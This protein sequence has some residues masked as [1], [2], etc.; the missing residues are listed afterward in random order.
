MAKK[1]TKTKKIIIAVV[2][3][4]AALL[5][6]FMILCFVTMG[7]YSPTYLGRVLT[8]WDSRVTDY[9]FFPERI[10][11]K[12]ASPYAYE[13]DI[14]SNL[15]GFTVN[16]KS[17]KRNKS[18]ALSSFV[19]KT[20]TTSLIIVKDDKI[21]YEQY[22]NGYTENSVNTSFSMSK[23]VVSLLVGKAVEEGYIKSVTQ[24]I[25][26]YI[27][28]FED[29]P[30][31]KVTIED[32]LLMRSPIKYDEEKPLW[33]GDDTLT[34]FYD[35]LRALALK[36]TKLTDEYGGRFHYNN[37][38][39]L[40]LGIILERSTGVSVSKYFERTIWQPIGCEADASWSLDGKKSA[41]EKMESGI[42]FRALDFIK[43]GSMVLHGGV[44]N[45]TRIIGE[46]WLNASTVCNFPINAE[47]YGGTFLEG[48]NVGYRYM[49][50]STPNGGKLDIFAWGKSDQLLYICPSQ[51]AVILRTGKSDGKVSNWIDI[52]QALCAAA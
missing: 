31:G 26:D 15:S 41:F 27:K 5:T 13:K 24:P 17:G 47:E 14:N 48:K 44:W 21:V 4:I 37:Y 35:D 11:E 45:G 51:N 6:A 19:E 38:H 1:L 20:D 23:S 9:K 10:I 36:H 2:T 3:P 42:N 50:Y 7:M 32:L 22:A 52:M 12:S 18:Y 46:D 16:Y 43:I 39:P 30:I 33:F 49:W 29:K 25:S 8:R 34:Y 28:E 40:L